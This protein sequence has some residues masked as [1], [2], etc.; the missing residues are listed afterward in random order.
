MPP[1]ANK[2]PE[3][4]SDPPDPERS[5]LKSHVV[6]RPRCPLATKPGPKLGRFELSRGTFAGGT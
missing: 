2:N 4:T 1:D 6:Q 5:D 3:R